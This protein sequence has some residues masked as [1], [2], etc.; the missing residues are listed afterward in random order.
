MD[1]VKFMVCILK[2]HNIDLV[3]FSTCFLSSTYISIIK[4]LKL[5]EFGQI[6]SPCA[7]NFNFYKYSIFKIIYIIM[8]VQKTGAL[9]NKKYSTKKKYIVPRN[10]KNFKHSDYNRMCVCVIYVWKSLRQDIWYHRIVTI[11]F[12]CERVHISA[13]AWLD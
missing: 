10:S 5:L 12:C 13:A 9:Q 4:E 7:K 11:K 6:L 3:F 8:R 2:F 1:V